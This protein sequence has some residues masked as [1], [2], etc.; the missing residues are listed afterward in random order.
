MISQQNI[1]ATTPTEARLVLGGGTFKV[2]APRAP[3]VY[4]NGRFAG[5]SYDEQAPDRLSSRTPPATGVAFKREP[6]MAIRTAQ[7][8][9]SVSFPRLAQVMLEICLYRRPLPVEDTVYAGITQNAARAD[10]MLPEDPIELRAEPL[11]AGAALPVECMRA[12]LD[13]DA[14]QPV[15]GVTQEQ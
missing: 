5:V 10:H 6:R 12:Q 15:E 9:M 14:A 2:W 3:A 11:D 1:A 8:R 4:L 13:G 7:L